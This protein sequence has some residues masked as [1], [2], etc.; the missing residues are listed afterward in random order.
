MTAPLVQ[1]LSLVVD[2]ATGQTEARMDAVASSARDAGEAAER[3]ASQVAQAAERVAAA[4]LRRDDAAGKV[5]VA[6]A[7]LV[8]LQ[9]KGNASASQMAAATERLESARRQL[10][11]SER[12]L[13]NATAESAQTQDRA[14]ESL[15]RQETQQERARLGS[16]RFRGQL[17]GVKEMAKGLTAFAIGDWLQEQVGGYL[18][19][20]RG[21]QALAT[22]MNASVEEGGRLATIF[23]SMGLESGDLLEIQAQ[24]AQTSKDGLTAAGQE[25]K[26]NRDGTVNWARSLED[27]LAQLQQIPDATERNRQG[28]QMFGEEGYKQ[29]SRLLTSGVSVKEAFERVGTPFTS[30]DVSIAQQYDRQ[31][32]QLQ[33]SSSELGR[34]LARNIVPVAGDVVGAL[35]K[36]LGMVTDIPLPLTLAAS[37][38]VI[39]G[40]TGFDP[41]AKSADFV[42]EKFGAVREGIANATAGVEEGAGRMSRAGAI[43]KG[44]V[45][46]LTDALGGPLGVALIGAGAAFSLA[47]QGEEEL[48]RHAADAAAE[49]AR[50]GGTTNDAAANSRR[51]AAQLEREAGTWETLM[52]AQRGLAAQRDELSGFQSV[53][54]NLGSAFGFAGEGATQL[55]SGTDA[56]AR[57]FQ[58][59]IDEARKNLGEFGA[60]E[61]AAQLTTASLTQMIAEGDTS[62]QAFADSV[63]EAAEAQITQST[64]S[65]TAAASIAAYRSQTDQAVQATR[66]LIDAQYAQDDA[67]YAFLAAVDAAN[68]AT[69]DQKTSVDEVAQAH[70]RLGEAALHAGDAMADVAVAQAKA[71]GEIVTPLDEANIRASTLIETLKDQLNTPDLTDQA[72]NQLQTLI[73]QLTEAKDK[74]DVKALVTLTGVD[75]AEDQLGKVGKDRDAKISLETRGGPAVSAYMD[76]LTED[77]L[78]II[79]VESRNGPAVDDY[80]D[81]LAR[82]RLAI[83]RVE[84]R[85]GPAVDQYLDDLAGRRRTAVIDVQRRNVG[86]APGGGGPAAGLLGAAAFGGPVSV[87]VY[88]QVDAGGRLTAAG[89]TMTGR[90]IVQQLREYE[91]RNGTGWRTR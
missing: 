88:P 26:T 13:T 32:M 76:R 31:M 42:R 23:Q 63:K 82:D 36:V 17:E 22:S 44:G 69:D 70:T 16:E 84:T 64:T 29:L 37:A 89:A 47:S 77:R 78:A 10:A 87:N 59:A 28:F 53:V 15:A 21:A 14:T 35:D 27:A 81:G 4:Q 5:A 56:A 72:R 79:R 73:D 49:V 75:T 54:S 9:E 30:E 51:L 2:A 66:G 18:E 48:E 86:G 1:R 90:Q 12:I 40:R 52:A 33:L 39:M 85:G 65:D 43:A 19:G 45:S 62:S 61:A 68:S 46:G 3:S 11:N 60:Q 74:G 83:I 7:R 24:F 25:L 91:R 67:E 58:E 50:L 80:L 20:A 41:L 71:A 57:G 34:T 6:E 38:A 55:F 8:E